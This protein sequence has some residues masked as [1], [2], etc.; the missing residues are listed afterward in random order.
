MLKGIKIR[1]YL[2]KEQ[3]AYVNQLLGTYRFVYNQSLSYKIEKYKGE[4][5]SVGFGELGRK[6]VELKSEYPWMRG[7]HSKVLQQSIIDMNKAYDAF[8]KKQN[9]FPKFKSKHDNRKSCRFPSDA[10]SGLNGNRI[11]IIK[12]LWN[13]HFKCSIS[14][15]KYLNKNQDKIRSGT[16]TKTPSGKYLFSI[17]I[18]DTRTKNLP[19]SDLAIGIDLGIK[20]FI[21]TSNGDRYENIK[22]RRSNEKGLKRLHR[23]LSRRKKGSRNRNKARVKLAKRYEKLNNRKEFYLHHIA[24]RLL[25]ENQ[26][27]AIEDLNVAGM[28]KNHKLAKS[29]QEL[30]ISRFVN[31]LEYK[32]E[33][34]GRSVVKVGRF[35]PSSKLCS[36]CGHKNGELTLKDRN[37]ICPKCGTEHDR[38]LNAAKNVLM[39]G[40]KIKI[41]LSSPELTPLESSSLE[42][43][44]N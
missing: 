26:T 1:L 30:S 28:M 19:E 16:L 21:V 6:L 38:D 24:N 25:S 27:I 13:V 8:F 39:E 31:I 7:S 2:N 32:A 11:N 18:D 37:W 33:W 15:Q 10:I 40:K 29:I 43:S 23:K 3:E 5:K 36:E 14:D 22:I 44:L 34:Y 4:K 12:S 17:L 9:S 20:D 41:G 35:F 42:H